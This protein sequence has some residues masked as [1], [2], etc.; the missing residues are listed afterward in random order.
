V[1]GEAV[2]IKRPKMAATGKE[3]TISGWLPLHCPACLQNAHGKP[4]LSAQ[5][6]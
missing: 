5:L 4:A 1:L 3:K 2:V 6:A